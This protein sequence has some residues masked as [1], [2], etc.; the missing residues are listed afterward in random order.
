MICE[1]LG[2]FTPFGPKAME[3][4]SAQDGFD[5]GNLG[6][7]VAMPPQQII[8][9]VN[10]G[11]MVLPKNLTPLTRDVVR[12]IL[13]AD[14]NVRLEIRDIMRHQFFEGVDWRA[15]AGKQARPPY[16]PDPADTRHLLNIPI[17]LEE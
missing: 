8:E 3:I 11:R 17:A 13:V 15:V 14:P 12:K 1:I 4:G 6:G 10:S 5:G 2:G 7:M 16:V 9:T